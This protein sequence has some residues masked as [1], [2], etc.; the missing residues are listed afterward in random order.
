LNE[1]LN[2]WGWADHQYSSEGSSSLGWGVGLSTQP[3]GHGQEMGVMLHRPAGGS[4]G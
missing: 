3:D 2:L 1:T 4:A